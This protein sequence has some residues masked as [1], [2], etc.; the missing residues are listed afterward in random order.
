MTYSKGPTSRYET[1]EGGYEAVKGNSG[2]QWFIWEHL[3]DVHRVLRRLG[4]AGATVSAKKVFVAVPEVI[5][6]GH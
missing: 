4:H 2:I 6:L 3:N 1:P 5:V